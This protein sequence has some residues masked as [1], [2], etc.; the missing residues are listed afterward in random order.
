MDAFFSGKKD[1]PPE[2]NR[3]R[4]ADIRPSL[5]LCICYVDSFMLNYGED[6]GNLLKVL[7]VGRSVPDSRSVSPASSTVLTYGKGR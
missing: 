4:V 1:N 3:G 5:A 7:L 2:L 6:V